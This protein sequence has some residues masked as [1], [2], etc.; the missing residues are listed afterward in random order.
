MKLLPE[1]RQRITVQH[2]QGGHMFYAWEP[3]RKAFFSAMGDF[4]A[5][6]F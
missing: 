3:S 6:S 2:F 1:Q 4:Y 5:A